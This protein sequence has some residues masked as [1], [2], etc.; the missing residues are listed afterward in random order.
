MRHELAKTGVRQSEERQEFVN[1]DHTETSFFRYTCRFQ[2]LLNP[3]K[4][5]ACSY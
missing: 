3:E 4:E 1:L 5:V 2:K